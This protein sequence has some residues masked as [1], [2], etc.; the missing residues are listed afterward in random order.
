MFCQY[1]GKEVKDN[2]VRCPYCGKRLA[3]VKRSVKLP[4]VLCMVFFVTAVIIILFLNITKKGNEGNATAGE[5]NPA[6]LDEGDPNKQ[7]TDD[8]SDSI[9]LESETAE[10]NDVTADDEETA[11]ASERISAVNYYDDD[12]KLVYCESYAYYENGLLCSTTLHSVNYSSDGTF[13][14]GDEYTFLYLYDDDGNLQDKVLDA[15]TIDDWFDRDTGEIILDYEFDSEGN[16]N[17]ITIYP[18]TE[19]IEQEK[20]GVDPEKTEKIYESAAIIPT[21]SGNGWA[22]A[23]L[24]DVFADDEPTDMT[25]CRFIY[26]DENPQPEL[27]MDYGYGYAGAEIYTVDNGI[28]DKIYLSHGFAYWIEKGNL[29][30]VRGGHM[31]N[32]YDEIY[33]IEDGKFVTLAA[34]DYGAEDNSNIQLDENGYPIYDYYW[35]GMKTSEDEYERQLTDAFDMSMAVNTYQ[36]IYTYD[37]CRLLLQAIAE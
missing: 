23:Y 35:N 1:C 20:Y 7:I 2:E 6:A 11:S 13:Y 10:G 12:G 4:I 31:D 32:Y 8:T 34:G 14:T 21:S 37:Q 17:E 36:N 9:S 5:D 3:G 16:S 19:S 27:W 29:L 26:V 18:E 24:R 15:L 33:K 22:S 28:T 25:T 30:L